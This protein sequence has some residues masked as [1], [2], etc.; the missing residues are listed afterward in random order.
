[1]NFSKI[2]K[3]ILNFLNPATLGFTSFIPTLNYDIVFN[4]GGNILFWMN[5]SL[6]QYIY[7]IV[8][9]V[10][11]KTLTEFN[12]Y[13]FDNIQMCFPFTFTFKPQEIMYQISI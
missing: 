8:L 7:T 12:F 6:P 3:K 5:S 1:M 2:S 11:M 4:K 13:L 10:H 9:Y